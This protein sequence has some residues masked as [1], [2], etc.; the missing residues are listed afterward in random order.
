M[1][2]RGA[3]EGE[4]PARGARPPPGPAQ[5]GPVPRLAPVHVA[6]GERPLPPRRL[7]G[8]AGEQEATVDERD[9]AGHHLLVQVIDELAAPAHH[10]GSPV[11]AD[12]APPR[13]GAAEGAGAGG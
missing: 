1:T 2:T 13:P 8:P 3:P 4:E 11:G 6:T 7:D 5:G 9:G 10:L 12:R